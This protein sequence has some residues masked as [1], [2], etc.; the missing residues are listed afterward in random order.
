LI[1]AGKLRPFAVS[2]ATRSKA[3]PNVPTMNELGYK[4]FNISQFQGLL[5]PA[6]T[7]PLII[8]RLHEEVVKALK[9]PS[10]VKRL[11]DDGGNEIIASSPTEFAN[12]I[13]SELKMYSKLIQAAHIQSE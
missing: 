7:D 1:K 9:V 11:V 10:T 2:S 8:K 5:A 13:Q 12:Q 6:G 3:I 4:G